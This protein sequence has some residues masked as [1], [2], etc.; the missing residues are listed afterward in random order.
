MNMYKDLNE[1][2]QH[3]TKSTITFILIIYEVLYLKFILPFTL[4]LSC[5]CVCARV[6]AIYS[7]H[8]E[9]RGQPS[10][11]GSVSHHVDFGH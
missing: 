2:Y 6:C 8:A 1:I 7:T 4:L 3:K 10:G 5:V 11:A 9:T